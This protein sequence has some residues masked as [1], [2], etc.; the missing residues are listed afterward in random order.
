MISFVIIL[1]VRSNWICSSFVSFLS[2]C[3]QGA[4]GVEVVLQ[5]LHDKFSS[6][7]ESTVRFAVV[8]LVRRDKFC[9]C[10]VS[11]EQLCMQ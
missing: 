6:Y 1:K 10:F 5:A 4:V 8:L 2:F 11:T 3:K 9:S 7:F